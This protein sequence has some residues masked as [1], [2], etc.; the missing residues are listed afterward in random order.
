MT[1]YNIVVC[2]DLLV[3]DISE[4][5]TSTT[6]I[7]I[8]DLV[9]TYGDFIAVDGITLSIPHKGIYGFLGPNGAGKTTTI[10]TLTTLLKPTSGSIKIDGLDVIEDTQEIRR[11]IGI[12][13]QHISLDKEINVRENLVSHALLH[14]VPCREIDARIREL[15]SILGLEP[16]MERLILDLSGGWR[17]RV[18][19]ACAL[20]HR[21]SILFLDEPTTGLDTQSRHML[22]NI[23]RDLKRSGTMVFLTTHYMDEAEALCDR[24]AIIDCGR[25]IAEGSPAELNNLVGKVAV[26]CEVDGSVFTKTFASRDMAK[27]FIESEL[28]EDSAYT[29]RRTTL[30]DVFLELTGRGIG[31]G[32]D[33]KDY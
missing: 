9:V 33:A 17:K 28:S 12:V 30:E 25:I 14:M 15:S 22:W 29:L 3:Q 20:I 13:Q 2:Y 23:V 8:E 11:S 10:K 32:D 16:Y 1:M 4:D 18:S 7:E 5:V 31:G 26:D 27:A 19:I 24:I 6:S 21:P